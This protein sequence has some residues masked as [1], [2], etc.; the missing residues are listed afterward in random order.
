MRGLREQIVLAI[1]VAVSSGA[2]LFKACEAIHLGLR[3]L[4]RWRET[5]EDGRKGGYRAL[6]QKLSEPEKDD[7]I[8]ALQLPD[9]E[10]LPLKLA[11]ATLLDRGIC[12]A[13]PSTFVRVVKERGVHR[14]NRTTRRA[15]SA[16]RPEL[17]ATAP[18]QVWLGH[19]VAQCA[20]QG[21]LFLPVHGHR[22]VLAQGRGMGSFREGGWGFSA[23]PVCAD[24]RGG[25]DCTGSN[26][27]PCGQRKADEE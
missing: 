17:V 11:H 10:E 3:R 24:V 25:R 8:A 12:L 23:R 15:Q 2:K 6:N 13:S 27:D 9:I 22:H 18:G 5:K 7:I 26:P 4:R 20:A 16:K 1:D 21:D 19:H 14:M